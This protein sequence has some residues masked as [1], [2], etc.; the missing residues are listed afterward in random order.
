MWALVKAAEGDDVGEW[1]LI[2]YRHAANYVDAL[3]ESYD[4]GTTELRSP[5]D[6]RRLDGV[7]ADRSAS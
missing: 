2:Y 1:L 6:N 4:S 5:L 7:R 3:L